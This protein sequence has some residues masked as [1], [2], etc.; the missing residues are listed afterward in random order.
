MNNRITL[1]PRDLVTLLCC[2]TI[3]LLNLGAIGHSGRMKAKELMCR[4]NLNQ[5]SNIWYMFTNG[6]DHKFLK[7]LNW[8][9]NL[10]AYYKDL[11]L[12]LCPSATK[13]G[14]FTNIRG[15]L[16]GN[17]FEAWE[18]AYDFG[19]GTAK[20]FLGSYGLNYWCTH[21]TG[22]GRF[23][24]YLWKTPYI[25]GVA[26]APLFSDWAAAGGAPLYTDNPPEWDGQLYVSDPQDVDEMKSVCIDRHNGGVNVLFA[27]FSVRKTGL[28]ELW[29]IPWHRSWN[30]YNDPLPIWPEWMQ[31][32]KE[33][34]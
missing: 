7:D 2:I 24:G 16:L 30:P 29:Q 21:S 1:S 18:S 33:P 31:K 32:Y 27:D 20:T 34:E 4:S 6:N 23:N 9:G 17:K 13:R 3:V 22:G 19:D 28:K 10:S 25:K 12:F 11:K 5:W 8:I 14:S 26:N 15:S